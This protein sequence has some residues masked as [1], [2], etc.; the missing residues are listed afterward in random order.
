MTAANRNL[1]QGG[2]QWGT[3]NIHLGAREVQ[4]L[5]MAT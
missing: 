2:V 1:N 4:I 5:A 3:D